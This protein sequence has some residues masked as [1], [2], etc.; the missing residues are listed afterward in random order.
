MTYE[1]DTDDY[2]YSQVLLLCVDDEGFNHIPTQA[3]QETTTDLY[4]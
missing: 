4:S 2:E 3:E 1:Y